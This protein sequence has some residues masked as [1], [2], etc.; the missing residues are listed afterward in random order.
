MH[1]FFFFKKIVQ[2]QKKLTWLI[3]W[4][5]S[6]CQKLLMMKPR[7]TEIQSGPL[8]GEEDYAAGREEAN[9]WY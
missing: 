6:S 1:G 9:Y 4:Q 8:T 2:K 5:V 3:F 7:L